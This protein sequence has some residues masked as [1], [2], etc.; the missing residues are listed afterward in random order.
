[1]TS[2]WT[3][4]TQELNDQTHPIWRH[5]SEAYLVTIKRQDMTAIG[6][7]VQYGA[8]LQIDLAQTDRFQEELEDRLEATQKIADAFEEHPDPDPGGENPKKLRLLDWSGDKDE[9]IETAEEFVKTHTTADEIEPVF[10]SEVDGGDKL[11]IEALETETTG[12]VESFESVPTEHDY[13]IYEV[14]LSTPG[15]GDDLAVETG[16]K[17]TDACGYLKRVPPLDEYRQRLDETGDYRDVT[18]MD[19]GNVLSVEVIE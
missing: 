2:T 14:F 17:L 19:F 11:R 18:T 6:G 15:V 16:R 1:M 10:W 4:D 9:V 5:N 12:T 8:E 13:E 3:R 7:T